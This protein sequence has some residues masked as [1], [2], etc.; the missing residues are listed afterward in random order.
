MSR[1]YEMTDLGTANRFLGFETHR[2]PNV[3]ASIKTN[4][5]SLI[6]DYSPMPHSELA[7]PNMAF[8]V[9]II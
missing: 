9:A 4:I 2:L 5:T 1:V 6:S 7:R 8:I 3:S